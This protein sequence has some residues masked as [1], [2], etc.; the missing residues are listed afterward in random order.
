MTNFKE[1][2]AHMGVKLAVAAMVIFAFSAVRASA[3]NAFRPFLTS[4]GLPPT[5]TDITALNE[6]H[7]RQFLLS[8]GGVREMEVHPPAHERRQRQ[9]ER[10]DGRC[11]GAAQ[12]QIGDVQTGRKAAQ[13]PREPAP[14][15]EH[16]IGR[17][18]AK[19]PLGD[20]REPV[21]GCES[22]LRAQT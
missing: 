21:A 12:V 22:P 8:L 3:F 16:G 5:N 13:C 2:M 4:V 1:F 15:P 7:V 18:V 17:Q 19:Q 9:P 20:D 14:Q 6:D 11:H 10:S